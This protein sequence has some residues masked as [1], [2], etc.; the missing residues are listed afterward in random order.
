MKVIQIIFCLFILLLFPVTTS[1]DFTVLK[2][3]VIS[4][5][6]G[7]WSPAW[8][9]DGESIAYIAYD[10][11]RNQQVFTMGVDGS[12][13][14][15]VT[16]TTIK[17]WGVTWLDGG[18]TYLSYDTDGLEKIFIVQPDGTG[19]RKLLDDKKRQGRNDAD[20]PPVFGEVSENP[21]TGKLLFTSL[22]EI[23]N[24][25]VYEV[26]IDGIGKKLVIDD[27]KRQWDP[28]W[29]P[30]GTSFVYV[31]YDDS[32]N[33]QLFTANADGTGRKQLTSDDVKKYDP[34]WGTG[35]IL[36][37]SFVDRF[38]SGEKLYIINPDGTGRKLAIADG[39][40]QKNPR[41]SADSSKVL[42]EDTDIKGNKEIKTLQL[43]KPAVVQT[44]VAPVTP[45]ANDTVSATPDVGQTPPEDVGVVPSGEEPEESNLKEVLVS[46]F[47]VLALI[48]LVMLAILLLSDLFSKK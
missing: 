29:N 11:S 1:A 39:F 2:T 20:K 14:K 32:N 37:V 35:G 34:N 27:G 17:K 33:M 23:H 9:P 41:W 42:Y 7:T 40:K 13:K 48:V 24:E 21:V 25:K 36:F 18:I 31:S 46:M 8:S 3:S 12:G 26:N 16:N 4:N 30:D 22:D 5:D 44:P 15:P 28:S 19:T 6:T 45:T 47:L 43:Q 38:A 10:D